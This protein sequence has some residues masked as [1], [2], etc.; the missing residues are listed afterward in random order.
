MRNQSSGELFCWGLDSDRHNSQRTIDGKQ[1][2]PP[3][4]GID[5]RLEDR[6]HRELPHSCGTRTS[7]KL[8]CW[9]GDYEGQVATDQTTARTSDQHLTRD[10]F[11]RRLR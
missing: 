3:Q 9:G 7:G 8:L 2:A 1:N 5:T 10:Y 4:V 6:G 11:R